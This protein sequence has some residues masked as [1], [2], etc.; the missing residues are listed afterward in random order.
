M[1]TLKLLRMKGFKSF[2]KL[3]EIP[4]GTGYNC[5]IGPNGSGKSNIMDAFTFVLG[6]T[7]AKSM[8]AEKSANLIFHGGKKGSPAK[9]ASVE[10][11]FDNSDGSFVIKDKEI[12]IGRMVKQN[13]Q[14]TYYINNEAVTRQQ[15]V[16]LLAS[17]KIDPD[18]HN[19]ILQGDIVS[20]MEMKTEDRRRIIED[21]SGISV[22]EDKKD[23]AM[24]ELTKVDSKL[25]EVKIILAEREAYMRELKKDRDQAKKYKELEENIR[26]NKATF[27]HL[28]MKDRQ[29]KVDEFNKR[30]AGLNEQK[31]KVVSEVQE[32]RKKIEEKKAELTTIN[33]DVE[34]RGEVEQK[35][36]HK[37]IEDLKT[38]EARQSSRLGVCKSEIDKLSSR[39]TELEKNLDE[40]KKKIATLQSAKK[41]AID[42]EQKL[43]KEE[44][45]INRDLEKFK[46]SH[47]LSGDVSSLD[48]L[49]E[50]FDSVQ[51]EIDALQQ[52][53]QA[54]VRERDQAVFE[55]SQ[56]GGD[57][58]K[59]KVKELKEMKVKFK[60][61]ALK[62]S[63]SLSENSSLVSQLSNARRHMFEAD[64]K[65]QKL[66]M[67]SAAVKSAYGMDLGIKKVLEMKDQGVHGTVSDLGKVS[68]KYSLALEVSAGAR[69]KSV[70]VDSDATAAKCISYLKD[71]KLGV[72]TFLPLN[73]MK[74]RVENPA[75]NQLKSASG[76]VGRAIDLVDYDKKYDKV[77]SYVFADTLVVEDMNAARK[78]GVGRARMVTLQGDLLEVS[79][80]MIGGFRRKVE[81]MGFKEKD[82]EADLFKFEKEVGD[83]RKLVD[84][85]ENRMEENENTVHKLREE[86]AEL[87]AEILKFEKLYGV[88]DPEELK[89]KQSSLQDLSKD[90][91]RSLKDV[92]SSLSKLS[93]RLQKLR[94]LRSKAKDALK[95]VNITSELDK[96]TQERQNVREKMIQY[97][98]VVK[99]ADDQ[100]AGL[101]EPELAKIQKLVQ[102]SLKETQSFKEEA[103]QIESRLKELHN[104]LKQKESAEKKFYADFKGLFEKRNKISELIQKLEVDVVKD[105]ERVR[106]VEQRV[107]SVELDRAK[108]VAELAGLEEEFK[109]FKEEKIRRGITTEELK[110][111]MHEFEQMMKTMGSVNLRALEVYEAAEKEYEDILGKTGKLEG[112]KNDV[113]NLI[114]DI[115]GKK[116]ELFMKTFQK[117]HKNFKEI[118]A[119][120]STKGEAVLLIEDDEN[121]FES[122]VDIQVR[123]TGNKFLDIKSMSGG[124]KTMAALAFIFAIQEFE[125]AAF[126]LLDEVDAALDK[127]N[128][129][130]LSKLIKKY[131]SKAQYVVISHNDTVITEADQVFG[132]SMQEMVSKVISLKL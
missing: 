32:T 2:P 31:N 14:S 30:I 50:E 63:K 74:E 115:D 97:Q 80:A 102:D 6:K 67:Q 104:E 25:N 34:S 121:I 40:L 56:L 106:G 75:L 51:K 109:E 87:E 42:D 19:I 66:S 132:V 119:S 47:N 65:L 61:V 24:G 28:Q 13:G 113:L 26:S 33:K 64:E 69:L 43:R 91:E 35:K 112:E 49:D 77:F 39:K 92:D 81:G 58:D 86:K 23:K 4:F 44:D 12:T 10:V 90:K 79:G 120:L 117:L 98:S 130:L 72:V 122:G 85:L 82:V 107:Q 68:S 38:E 59:E 54:L 3:I 5:I 127:R 52:Q 17:A 45:R 70:V 62:L 128:S 15:V 55:L 20:F 99:N 84:L 78:I 71:N 131:S 41:Q 111:E 27:I 126:Y 73:K 57:G 83:A 116:R 29:D 11:V 100:I 36:L 123:I 9:E 16:D 22:Y 108:I 93:Q 124:E 46:E 105:E 110:K 89:E 103:S 53:K 48:K 60:D 88:A 125:P 76:V 118:F 18:S 114:A 37:D 94:E 8:R 95:N 101:Y 129:E 96:F 21:V 7:S 1:A